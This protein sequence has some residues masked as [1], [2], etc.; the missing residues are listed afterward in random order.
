MFKSANKKII[1]FFRLWWSGKPEIGEISPRQANAIQKK[2]YLISKKEF[3]Q[4]CTPPYVAVA[5]QLGSNKQKVFEAAVFYLCTIAVNEPKY[6][7]AILH[8]LDSYASEHEKIPQRAEYIK[9]MKQKFNFAT[10]SS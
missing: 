2:S 9:N 8:V 4:I 6:E 1:E 5:A 10:T 3:E 7:K